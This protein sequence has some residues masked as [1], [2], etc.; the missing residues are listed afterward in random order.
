LT[1]NSIRLIVIQRATAA[2]LDPTA[3]GAHSLR[4]FATE[5]IARS[6]PE[7]DVQH[8]GRQRSRALI[9]PYIDTARTFDPTNPT[10]WL[11]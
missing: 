3:W 10:R 6:V 2:R 8:H 1:R 11:D 9:H 7:R 5:A 4:G